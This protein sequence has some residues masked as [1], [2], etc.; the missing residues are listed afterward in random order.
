MLL[1]LLS[2]TTTLSTPTP[3][4]QLQRKNSTGGMDEGGRFGR[5]RAPGLPPALHSVAVNDLSVSVNEPDLGKAII[6]E[7]QISKL[8]SPN[9]AQNSCRHRARRTRA[10]CC[11]PPKS[12]P[13]AAASQCHC[14][15][16][17]PRGA[18]EVEAVVAKA[19]AALR[20]NRIS[21]HETVRN[22]L[23]L[24][25]NFDDQNLMHTRVGSRCQ[26]MCPSEI[27]HNLQGDNSG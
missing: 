1:F 21:I 4:P 2:H 12:C 19:A 15:R 3:R 24:F 18:R 14:H 27:T 9:L 10:R 11:R 26:M 16:L 6:I 22:R 8:H 7:G 17:A 23:F 20:M 5:P 25:G 13:T